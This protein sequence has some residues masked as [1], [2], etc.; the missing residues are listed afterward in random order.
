MKETYNKP[1]SE[2]EE[3]ETVDVI[4]TSTAPI[5]H[6]DDDEGF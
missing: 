1:V 3:F 2:A 4:T 6:G 5:E